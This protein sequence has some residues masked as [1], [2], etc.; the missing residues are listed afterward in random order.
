[1]ISAHRSAPAADDQLA[2]QLLVGLMLLTLPCRDGLVLGNDGSVWLPMADRSKPGQA[3]GQHYRRMICSRAD[4][5]IRED[6]DSIVPVGRICRR[7]Q[8]DKEQTCDRRAD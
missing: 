4:R 5:Q 7:E 1:M 8:A 3:R 2:V 6:A